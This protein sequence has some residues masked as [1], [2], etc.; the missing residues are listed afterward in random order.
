MGLG[1]HE[2]REYS[3]PFQPQR[4]LTTENGERE[5][6]IFQNVDAKPE[7]KA[8]LSGNQHKVCEMG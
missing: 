5:G 8:I 6:N 3:P 1:Y 7:S 4:I 2:T